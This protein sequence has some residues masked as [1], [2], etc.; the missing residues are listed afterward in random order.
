[1]ATL[2]ALGFPRIGAKRELEIAQE[3]SGKG[4]SSRDALERRE[5]STTTGQAG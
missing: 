1:M 2:H 3:S 5:V 4:E